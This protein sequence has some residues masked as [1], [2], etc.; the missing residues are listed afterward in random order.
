MRGPQGHG[1]GV[2]LG[3]GLP[4]I[5]QS[6]PGSGLVRTEVCKD[7]GLR[8]LVDPRGTQNQVSVNKES[9]PPLPSF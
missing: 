1:I 8:L 9:S 2:A 5:A 4:C 6:V 3:L 7:S